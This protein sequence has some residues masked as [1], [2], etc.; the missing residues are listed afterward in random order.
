MV[1]FSWKEDNYSCGVAVIQIR[2]QVELLYDT[3]PS[4]TE[5]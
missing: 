2:N 1:I 4:A 5:F 3:V